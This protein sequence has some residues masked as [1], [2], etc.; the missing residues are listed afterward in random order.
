MTNNI[1]GYYRYPTIY[2][3]HI[4]FVAEDDLWE[5]PRQGG[6]AR[7]LTANLGTVST[8]YYSPDGQWIAFTSQNEGQPEVYVMSAQGGMAKRLTYFGSFCQIVGWKNNQIVFCSAYGQALSVRNMGLYTVDLEGHL[9]QQLPVGP[10]RNISF[11][12]NGKGSIIGRNTTDMARWKRY[13][14]GTA[15]QLWIDQN[16][17]GQFQHFV[18]D[19][20]AALHL[21]GNINAPMWVNNR[22][23][24]LSD[25]EGIAN[26]YSCQ[27]D[28]SNLQQHSFQKDY[29]A[30]NPQTDGQHIVYHAGGDLYTIDLATNENTK[31]KVEFHSPKMQLQRKF[32][33]PKNYLQDFALN[34]EGSY[35]TTINRG[36][37]FTFANWE[38]AVQQHGAR[39]GVRYRISRYLN[40]GDAIV[41]V[42]DEGGEEHLQVHSTTSGAV[43][44]LTNIAIGR[45]YRLKV[46][47]V[48]DE[49]LLTNQRQ[50]L[51]WVDLVKETSKVIVGITKTSYPFGLDFDW[52]PDGRYIAYNYPITERIYALKLYDFET[53]EHHQITD[54]VLFDSQPTFDPSGRYLYFLSKRYFDPSYDNIHFDLHFAKSEKPYVITL[55]KETL[56]PLVLQPKR[57]DSNGSYKS[58]NGKKAPENINIDVDNIQERI[59][60]LPLDAGN[61]LQLEAGKDKLFYLLAPTKGARYSNR[62]GKANG[63]LGCLDLKSLEKTVL[64]SKVEQIILSAD[65]RALA[66]T[67]NKKLRVIAANR[68]ESTLPTDT[69]PNRKSGWIDL[70]RLKIAVQPQTEWQQMFREA[71]RL[72]RD[73]FW[74]ADMT[75]IDWQ[76]IYHRYAPLVNRLGSRGELS[77]LIWEM[78]GELGTSHAYEFGGDYRPKPNYN[79]GFLGADMAYHEEKEAYQFTKIVKGDVWDDK[80][81]S[82]LKRPGIYITEGMLLTAVD[83]QAVSKKITPH[84]LLANRVKEEVQL[85][86]A[87]A[88]GSNSRVVTVKTLAS[89]QGLRYRDWVEANRTYVHKNS[90]GKVGYVHIPDMMAN[91]FA[92]FHRY[93]LVELDYEGLIIDVRFNGGGHISQLLLTK[94]A[95]RRIAYKYARWSNSRPY[96]IDSPQGPMVALANERAGSDGDI[97]SHNFKQMGLGPLIGRRTWG[98]VIGIWTRT[99]LADGSKTTQPEF[100]SYM[101]D[102]GYQVENYGTD[103]TIEM[104]ITPQQYVQG[105][106]PQLDRGI[107]EVL[108][109]IEQTTAFQP[110]FEER[111]KLTLPS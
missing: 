89:E 106:D 80:N 62:N 4:V 31:V 20:Y 64:T 95:R 13:R 34:K 33:T 8:P 73:Y 69:K 11:Q 60:A 49:V 68:E 67:S 105:V 46:S 6:V 88:D 70:N 61:Y 19:Q 37:P 79:V 27:P 32:V 43:K 85:T 92:E 18:G 40:Q 1:A 39:Q 94:L 78:Q 50:E 98:G 90:S 75:D 91:G 65:K 83:G 100:A 9:P 93:F 24:F 77:D 76:K 66:Y 47:P 54:G 38:G 103:P 74:V 55:Q 14:G 2:Q 72:Q 48:K 15:G 56:S 86:V 96:P 45:P 101:K 22:I 29:Y 30:R 57:F 110:N 5:V 12:S 7:R 109:I 81:A 41:V 108:A 71:W 17:D 84:Q 87:N 28:A 16:G 111:P 36:K 102:V 63:E 104:D 21:K 53:G 59:V 51:I 10:A 107:E 52:S 25:H 26:I 58:K 3:H 23:Y 42:C 99:N 35:L 82:P 97:F 44:K